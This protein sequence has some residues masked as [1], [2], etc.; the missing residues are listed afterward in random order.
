MPNDFKLTTFNLNLFKNLMSV[1]TKKLEEGRQKEDDSKSAEAIS[2]YEQIIAY[3]F[4]NEDELTDENIRAKEQGAY[5]LA[6]IFS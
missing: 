6:H 3:K 5:R 1:L 4:A 2:V